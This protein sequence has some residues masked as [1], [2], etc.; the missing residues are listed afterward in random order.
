[1]NPAVFFFNGWAGAFCEAKTCL[2][3]TSPTILNPNK[4]KL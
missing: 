2:D 1:M 3:L 4:P